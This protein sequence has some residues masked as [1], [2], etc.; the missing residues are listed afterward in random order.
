[1][2]PGDKELGNEQQGKNEQQKESGEKFC[3]NRREYIF[4]IMMG[5]SY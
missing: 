4:L 2:Q 5:F 1:M 3:R